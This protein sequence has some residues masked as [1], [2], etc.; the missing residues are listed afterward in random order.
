M[1]EGKQQLE[2]LVPSRG[3]IGFKTVFVNI[4][5]GEGIMAR[6]FL[7]YGKYRGALQGVR[8]G[9]PCFQSSYCP[10]TSDASSLLWG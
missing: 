8:K 4:T 6:S 9:E 7:N 1:Q 3:M 5:R 2:F 10:L